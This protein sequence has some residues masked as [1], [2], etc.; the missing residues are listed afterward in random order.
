M[1]ETTGRN[2]PCPCGSGKKYK[3]CCL[4]KKDSTAEVIHLNSRRTAEEPVD[5]LRTKVSRFMERE[6]FKVN[7]P[8]AVKLFWQTLEE[9]LKPPPMK[10]GDMAAI[11]EWCVHDY[12]QPQY[13]KPIINLFFES[14]P[15]LTHDELQILKDWQ[16]TNISVYQIT[17]VK[18]GHGVYGEDIFTGEKCFIHDISIS[19]VIQQWELLVSRK[20]WVLNEWQLSAA[21][22]HFSP[23]D[24]EEIYE[25][26]MEHFREYQKTRPKA[27]ITDFLSEHGYLLNHYALNRI[28]EQEKIPHLT[29]PEGDDVIICEALFDAID[30]DQI[31]KTLA[32]APDYQMT[33]TVE[34]ERGESEKYT[35]DWVT[36]GKPTAPLRQGNR[37]K[38]GLLYQSF[39][40]RGP[41]MGLYSVLG[42]ITVHQEKVRLSVLSKERLAQGKTVL[43][44]T[45]G[46]LIKHKI[47]S[48]QSVESRMRKAQTQTRKSEKNTVDP[49]IG[50]QI[51]RDFFDEHYR[52]WLD[53]KIPALDNMTPRAASKTKEGKR[54]VED[55]LRMIEYTEEKR[56]AESQYAYDI[57]WIRKE[58]GLDK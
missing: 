56:R 43:E 12:I 31:V 30:F 34:N 53:R 32:N 20:V 5:S 2:D 57:L 42:N 17:R 15:N 18:S 35:F 55:L 50:K 44:K 58:L 38:R 1:S 33:G 46:S 36:K 51:F 23:W 45:L 10:Q 11:T 49:E 3:K 8:D 24:K 54:A 27:V 39:F 47:D 19:K 26:I 14:N 16:K 29:T 13:G 4:A 48:L 9:E 21:G 6:D 41:G 25:F 40:T 7:F 52:R 37:K 22:R 28:V